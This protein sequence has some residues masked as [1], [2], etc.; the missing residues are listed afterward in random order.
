[1][2][3]HDGHDEHGH[4]HSDPGPDRE[5]A[6]MQAYGSREV[7][8]GAAITVIGLVVVFGLPLLLA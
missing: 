8:L 7:G 3:E 1:M 6:P 5:T 4:D 2:D